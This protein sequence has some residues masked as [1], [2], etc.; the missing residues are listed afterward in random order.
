MQV[1]PIWITR[2]A[3][4][5]NFNDL[6]K[7]NT[8]YLE[9]SAKLAG[10]SLYD[11]QWLQRTG[12]GTSG[13]KPFIRTDI[14]LVLTPDLMKALKKMKTLSIDFYQKFAMSPED[15][16]GLRSFLLELDNFSYE[17]IDAKFKAVK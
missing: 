5:L 13:E 6:Q 14:Q 15:V 11:T 9:E 10:K 3:D 2:K 4:P 7:K 1:N 16:A 8:K 17:S 12:T